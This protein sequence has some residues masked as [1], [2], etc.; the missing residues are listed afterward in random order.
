MDS[1]GHECSIGVRARAHVLCSQCSADR[2]RY[3]Q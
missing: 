3:V 2:A 1:V